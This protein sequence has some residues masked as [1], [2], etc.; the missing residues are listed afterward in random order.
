MKT[1]PHL[2]VAIAAVAAA[3]C[4]L[5]PACSK[6]TAFDKADANDN[7]SLDRQE[8]DRALLTLIFM[9]SDESD[10]GRVTFEEWKQAN[11]DAVSSRFKVADTDG[12]GAVTMEEGRAHFAREGTFT[13]LF[14]KMDSDTN[15][16]LDRGEVTTFYDK[17]KTQSAGAQAAAR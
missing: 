5:L 10:D 15:A 7:G 9:A 12:N 6:E 14:E 4:L 11:P 8:F 16:V 13:D 1:P 3:A 17:L 2:A